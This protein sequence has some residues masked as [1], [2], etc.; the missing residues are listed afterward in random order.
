[1]ND[2]HISDDRLIDLCMTAPPAAAEHA[3]LTACL[4]CE[5]RRVEIVGILEE[6]DE[7]AT[8]EAGTVFPDVKLER[9]HARILQRVDHD[10]RPGRLVP[11]PAHQP[12]PTFLSPTRPRVRWAAAVAAAAFVAGVLTGQWTHS[13]STPTERAPAFVV[14]N[15]AEREPLRA[16]PTTFSE[17]EFLGQIE[18]AASRN[19][20]AALRPLD[21]MTPR[22]WEVR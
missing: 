13:F 19:G 20:P 8:H 22:A 17:E 3:H 12:S 11:F 15:E 7:A 14:V 4:R 9:Q 16:V 10:G 1:M 5:A 18:V 6:L 2:R 21:A